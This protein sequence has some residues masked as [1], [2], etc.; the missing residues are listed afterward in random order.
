MPLPRSPKRWHQRRRLRIPLLLLAVL[1][2][3]YAGACLLAAPRPPH[4]FFA[5]G[6]LVIAHRGGRGLVPEN[7]LEAFRNAVRLGADVLEMDVRRS[8]DGEWVVIHDG[9]VRRTTQDSG[10]VAELSL[11]RLKALD[12][13]YRWSPDGGRGFPYRG[14]GVQIPTLAEVLEA[15]P[16]QRLNIELKTPEG[17]EDFCGVLQRFGRTEDVLVASFH[18]DAVRAFRSACPQTPTG[19]TFAEGLAFF[20]LNRLYLDAAYA[21]PADALQMPVRAGGLEVTDARFAR[22]AHRHR[23][24]VHAW[25]VNDED[26]MRR[27][28]DAG[29]DGV[30]TDYPDRLLRLLG[31]L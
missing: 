21:P 18:A 23:I 29:I 7:T 26:E 28:L 14:R 4:P 20:A 31:R 15:F 5:D 6:P 10:R 19:A 8:A 3:C 13:A 30:I 25:T 24:Q 17:A 11:R 2:G 22:G 16:G 12:A 1:A 9:D 27:L